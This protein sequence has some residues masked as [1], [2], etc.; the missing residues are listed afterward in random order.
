MVIVM[1]REAK[2]DLTSDLFNEQTHDIHPV[3][4]LWLIGGVDETLKP[5]GC[6]GFTN[7]CCRLGGNL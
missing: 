5:G 3:E 7:V 4:I 1:G 2:H 6:A